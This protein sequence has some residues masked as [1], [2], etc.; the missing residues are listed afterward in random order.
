MSGIAGINTV[1]DTLVSKK[2]SKI[3]IGIA[4]RYQKVLI[5]ELGIE[6]RYQEVSITACKIGYQKESI[7]K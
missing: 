2:V 3:K 5:P 7:P 1:I 4:M 6:K